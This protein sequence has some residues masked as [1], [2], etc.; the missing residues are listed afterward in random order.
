VNA[1]QVAQTIRPPSTSLLTIDS[2]DRYTDYN[3]SRGD[4][5]GN[6]SSTPYN[7]S[8]SKNESLM[9]GFLTRCGI[10]EICF[11]WVIPN[12]NVKTN[13]I[14]FAYQDGSNIPVVTSISLEYG[15]YTPHSLA[16]A[17]VAEITQIDPL[18]SAFTMEYGNT[19][20]S[21][22]GD[23][24][25]FTYASNNGTGVAFLPWV[26]NTAPYPF[27]S[28]TKQLFDLLGFSN[29]NAL[30]TTTNNIGNYTL[31]Q[32]T[33]YI[34]IVCNQLTN[35]Q[36]LKDQTSQS[37]S[38]DMLCRIYLGDG[39]GTGQSTI[40]PSDASFC[41]PGCAP[42]TIYRNFAT[43]KQIQWIPNQPIPGYL[44][45]QVFD[46]DGNPLDESVTIA[47][48]GSGHNQSVDWSMTLQVSEN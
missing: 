5:A 23:E 33:R 47:Q 35:N 44:A 41:P 36:A 17:L 8:I 2:E 25:L 7:F 13:S 16:Q 19:G 15:F 27:S 9:N 31:C 4:A 6:Y 29:N 30:L 38:R 1:R 40:A 26:Y 20:M 21:N 10:T 48:G 37:I 34:D 22:Y 24:P 3:A 14:Q 32:C 42:M 28:N 43:P 12:I 39:G 11:P 46:Q 45:F 18:L